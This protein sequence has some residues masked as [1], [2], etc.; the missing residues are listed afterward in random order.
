MSLT[1]G[2]ANIHNSKQGVKVASRSGA[3]SFGINEGGRRIGMLR[4]LSRYRE[5]HGAG[6]KADAPHR[7]GPSSPIITRKNLPSL[8]TL[9]LQVSEQVNASLRVA[10]DR[11]ITV[12]CFEHGVGPVAHVNIHPNAAV[13]GLSMKNDRVAEYDEFM[14][15]L[16]RLISFLK[17]EGFHV[18][19]TGDYNLARSGK[20]GALTPYQVFDGH[21]MRVKTIGIDGI[22]WTTGLTLRRFHKIPKKRLRSDH[23]GFT[24]TFN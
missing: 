2:H 7:G 3:D 21:G 16:N 14:R 20:T 5:F 10:P 11:W 24:A 18:V 4:A 12:S 15:S 22:A 13:K 8:G 6:G 23:N 9:A 1:I 19:V 17:A